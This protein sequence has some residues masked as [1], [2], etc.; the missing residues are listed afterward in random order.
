MNRPKLSVPKTLSFVVVAAAT[1]AG[2]WLACGGST[3]SGSTS[4]GGSTASAGGTTSSDQAICVVGPDGGPHQKCPDMPGA[5]HMCPPGC[6]I[7]V[8]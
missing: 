3:S 2:P 8:V 6:E 7:E 1:L 5:D 4:G